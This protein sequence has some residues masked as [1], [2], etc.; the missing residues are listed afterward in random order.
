GMAV[1]QG[2]VVLAPSG[3]GQS[4]RVLSPP[5]IDQGQDIARTPVQLADMHFNGV[6][7]ASGDITI[8]G[9]VRLYGAVVAGGTITSAGSGSSLEVWYDHD[10]SRGLY[11]GLPVVY[12]APGTWMT[13]Y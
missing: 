2:H 13:R 7:H 3:S 6:L 10:L 4:I 8:A 5:Q 11:R 9:R 12:R 1:V